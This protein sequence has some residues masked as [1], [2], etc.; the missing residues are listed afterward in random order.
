MSKLKSSIGLFAVLAAGLIALAILIPALSN[1]PR[2]QTVPISQIVS[3]VRA[4]KIQ[5]ITVTSGDNQIVAQYVDGTTRQ[6]QM[7]SGTTVLGYLRTAGI[8]ATA[9]P[10]IDVQSSPSMFSGLG[11][12]I[13]IL[14]VLLVGGVL[15]YLLTSSRQQQNPADPQA[16]YFSKSR[17][18]VVRSDRPTTSFLDVAGVEEA[19][20]ELAEIV[21]FLKSPARFSALGARVPRGVLLVG[22]PGTGKTLLARAVAGEAGVPFFNISGSEFVEMFVG[23]GAARVRDLFDQA[24]RQAPAIVFIDEIDAV[25]RQRGTGLGGGHDEREQT[26]N[27]ILVE[28]DGFDNNTNII[29]MA[30]TNRADIL[31]PALTRPGRFD[32]Q[33]IVDRPDIR[34][35]QQILEVH[36]RGKPIESDVSLEVLAKQTAGFSGADLANAVNEAAILAARREKA[37][38]GL[39]EFEDAIDRV[40][41]GPERKSRVI[42]EREKVV[43]AYHEIG[44][45]LAARLLPNVDPVHK[46]SIVARGTMGGYTRLLPVEDRYLYTRSQ[47][48][49]TIVWALGGYVA[50]EVVFGEATTGASNDIERITSLARQMVTRYGMST[51]LGPISLGQ[52]EQMV[53]LG[54]DLGEGRT[55]GERTAEEIDHEVRDIIK[56]AYDRCHNLLSENR[57]IL[58]RV[59]EMLIERETIEGNDLETAFG[60]GAKTFP[61]RP[62]PLLGQPRMPAHGV[63]ASVQSDGSKL[64]GLG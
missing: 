44:H 52:G 11:N 62:V 61:P 26:L 59:S 30:A 16:S 23:V 41:A 64:H 28:M 18:R 63:A 14:P 7:E 13:G 39:A 50:E 19:K 31:D 15:I 55:Y 29:V 32:R 5:K 10:Q 48:E 35:R 49:E 9:M 40:V 43:T 45:A 57:D 8:P 53:F 54:R 58:V 12:L 6:S 17:A 25:G 36:A 2:D 22:P 24:K 1:T 42:S 27:Q 38:I 34:G 4:G 37:T 33:V 3:D 51:T 56:S 46:V 21:E 20:Q 47:F 60:L